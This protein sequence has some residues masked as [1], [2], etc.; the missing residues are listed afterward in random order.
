[1]GCGVLLL[2][3]DW[4]VE[5]QGDEHGYVE[6]EDTEEAGTGKSYEWRKGEEIFSVSTRGRMEGGIARAQR[7]VAE[8]RMREVI[9]E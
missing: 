3:I 8:E 1:M 6:A 9:T 4:V 2:V 7:M 5:D